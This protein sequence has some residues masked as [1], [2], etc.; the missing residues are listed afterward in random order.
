MLAD[1]GRHLLPCFERLLAL[2]AEGTRV[3]HD[4]PLRVAGH[5]EDLLAGLVQD[6]VGD[7]LRAEVLV[8]DALAL[9]VNDEDVVDLREVRHGG[10][11]AVLHV[12]AR[13]HRH[14]VT[15]ARVADVALAVRAVEQAEQARRLGRV[16]RHHLGVAREVAAREHGGG[17]LHADVRPV[18]RLCDKPGHRATVLLE[19]PTER[20]EQELAARL[21]D[22]ALEVR[23]HH[24]KAAL[25]ELG[26]VAA[27]DELGVERGVALGGGVITLLVGVAKDAHLTVGELAQ[28]VAGAE[29]HLDD[30]GARREAPVDRL[31]GVVGPVLD[32]E[33]VRHLHRVALEA[34]DERPLV[35]LKAVGELVGAVN[36]ADLAAEVPAAH[37]GRG[38]LDDDDLRA[39]LGG[40][41]RRA[42]ACD[43][44]AHHEDVRL[45][46][47][48]DRRL[49]DGVGGGEERRQ[50]RPRRPLVGEG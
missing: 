38:L 9:A 12:R 10:K 45:E 26:V 14:L 7:G 31:A 19:V 23:E 46:G 22:D 50:G 42:H 33:L 5:H 8:S 47:L 30:V 44:R 43:A 41:A 36:R 25:V 40:G 29:V 28:L 4:G 3:E 11:R 6:G 13:P 24:L 27:D 21:L 35:D 48:G 2:L 16:V 34:L 1:C 49:V 20:V 37:G 39:R 15:V 17:R 32:E 18:L